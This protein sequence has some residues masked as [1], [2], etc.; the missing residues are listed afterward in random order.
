MASGL[1]G[2]RGP[3]FRVWGSGVRIVGGFGFGGRAPAL[4]VQG[5]EVFRSSGFGF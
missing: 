2:L 5:F 3:E 1:T 4:W